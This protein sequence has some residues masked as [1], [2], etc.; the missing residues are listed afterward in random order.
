MCNV[1]FSFTHLLYTCESR[2]INLSH[3]F[4]AGCLRLL[5]CGRIAFAD[6]FHGSTVPQYIV[7]IK[8]IIEYQG[9]AWSCTTDCTHTRSAPLSLSLPPP[10]SLFFCQKFSFP[11]SFYLVVFT[12]KFPT[13]N[14]LGLT[15][16]ISKQKIMC[17]IH[18]TSAKKETRNNN[19]NNREI[20]M[21]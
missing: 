18:E 15:I 3:D 19:N 17:E 12:S 5:W 14:V 6:I 20:V 2:K 10:S 4:G 11:F 13:F 8:I 1:H 9:R 7:E 21:V 16:E